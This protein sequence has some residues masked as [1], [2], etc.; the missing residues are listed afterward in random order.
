MIYIKYIFSINGS[1]S[2]PEKNIFPPPNTAE[3]CGFFPKV[4]QEPQQPGDVYI[5]NP[6]AYEHGLTYAAA[7]WDRI[8]GLMAIVQGLIDL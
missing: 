4:L 7:S 5:G 8:W 3:I 6:A 1:Y 2:L